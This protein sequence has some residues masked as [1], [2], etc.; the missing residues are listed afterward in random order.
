MLHHCRLLEADK[1]SSLASIVSSLNMAVMS[2]SFKPLGICCKGSIAYYTKLTMRFLIC[3]NFSFK[4][5]TT[6]CQL[7]ICTRLHHFFSNISFF[8][9]LYSF[10]PVLFKSNNLY[11]FSHSA[12]SLAEKQK[13]LQEVEGIEVEA[14]T[15][16]VSISFVAEAVSQT[17]IQLKKA[18]S[19]NAS[20]A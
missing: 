3:F 14:S 9:P 6:F 16:Y 19:I 7:I 15:N 1:N 8:R 4:P 18:L 10:L 12:T 5:K 11:S 2:L 20:H 17:T 13:R